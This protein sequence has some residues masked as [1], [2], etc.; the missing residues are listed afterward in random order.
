MAT[1]QNYSSGY[2]C[3]FQAMLLPGDRRRNRRRVATAAAGK[4]VRAA[5]NAAAAAAAAAAKAAAA[6]AVALAAAVDSVA[7]AL[8]FCHQQAHSE[9]CQSQGRTSCPKWNLVT[10]VMSKAVLRKL[11]KGHDCHQVV[12]HSQIASHPSRWVCLGRF[13]PRDHV[14]PK[15]AWILW[16]KVVARTSRPAASKVDQQVGAFLTA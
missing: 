4:V 1:F 16:A 15:T 3:D 5:T 6:T 8:A 9:A 7:I 13:L 10:E 2:C 14:D 12:D 11:P